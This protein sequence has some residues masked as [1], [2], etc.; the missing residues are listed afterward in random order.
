MTTKIPANGT[1]KPVG[2]GLAPKKPNATPA[3]NHAQREAQEA[4]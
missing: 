1:F 4:K 3:D 2:G